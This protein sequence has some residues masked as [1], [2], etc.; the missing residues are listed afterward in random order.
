MIEPEDAIEKISRVAGKINNWKGELMRGSP[1][2]G[3]R[4]SGRS[5]DGYLIHIYRF[6]GPQSEGYNFRVLTFFPRDVELFGETWPDGLE[7]MRELFDRID[8]KNYRQT[9]VSNAESGEDGGPCIGELLEGPEDF[10]P[11]FED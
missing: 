7:R 9:L 6:S 5:S 1:H 3:I 11:P 2:G 4:Y 10:F 8:A